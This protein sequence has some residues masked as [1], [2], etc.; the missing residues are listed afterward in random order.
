[1]EEFI[2]SKIKGTIAE[3]IIEELFQKL[4]FY[5]MKLGKEYTI[6]PLTQLQK[7]IKNCNGKF[8]LDK[9]NH[10]DIIQL[11]YLNKLPDFI[12]VN[13]NGK[14]DMLEVKFRHNAIIFPKDLEF[15]ELYREGNMLIVNTSV[16]KEFLDNIKD[17]E[18]KE[19]LE[20]TRF[21][22]IF[23]LLEEEKNG[24][25]ANFLTLKN[26]LKNEFNI[27]NDELIEKYEKLV[28]KWLGNKIVEESLEN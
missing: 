5:V 3:T 13:K 18:G 23:R 11:S 17:E 7:F 27:E 25:I 15:L 14:V 9:E 16:C 4:G 8:R 6:N 2:E 22:I 24:P 1:M 28:E 10:K 21:H 19:E 12:I 20:K 26:F